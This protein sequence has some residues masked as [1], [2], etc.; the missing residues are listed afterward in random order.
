MTTNLHAFIFFGQYFPT[1]DEAEQFLKACG[2]SPNSD[3]IEYADEYFY[4]G[5]QTLNDS[6]AALGFLVQPGVSDEDARDLWSNR[7]SS[8]TAAAE[9]HLVVYAEEA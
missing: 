5:L 9:T 7:I 8:C 4:L 3:T 6:R 1:R 2:A